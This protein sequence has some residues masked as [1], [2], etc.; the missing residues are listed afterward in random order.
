MYEHDVRYCVDGI[1]AISRVLHH[2]LH[3][4]L[5]KVLL[6]SL[7]IIVPVSPKELLQMCT[8]WVAIP[9]SDSRR[10]FTSPSFRFRTAETTAS[11]H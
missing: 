6:G 7:E 11:L 4:I 3:M 10:P 9:I 8:G 2:D 5:F 1:E